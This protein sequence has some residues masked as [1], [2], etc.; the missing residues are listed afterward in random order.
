MTLDELL[1]RLDAIRSRGNGRHAARC[2]AHAD[3]N[4]SL[5]VS[6]GERG[7]LLRCWSGC[8]VAEICGSLGIEQRDLF[9]DALD[10]N[11][12]QR[13]EAIQQRDRQ[14]QERERHDHQQGALVDALREADYFVRSR[15]GLDISMW[16]DDRLDD[17][18]DALADASHLLENED[19]DGCL[20]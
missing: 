14:R 11:P 4:P 2:P 6:E 20:G 10:S 19:L 15:Q 1:P 18:L 8:T 17:E 13:R 16:S 9:F 7:I 3:K 12:S 5:S